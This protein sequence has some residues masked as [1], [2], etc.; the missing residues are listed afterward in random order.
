MKKIVLPFLFLIITSCIYSQQASDLFKKSD[1]KITYLGIDFSKVRLIGS[2]NQFA[3]AGST[4]PLLIKNKYFDAWNNIVLNESKKYDV[5][6]IF[7]KETIKMDIVEMS[8]INSKTELEAIEAEITPKYSVDFIK[9]HVSNYKFNEKEGFGILFIAE[10]LDKNAQEGI[11]HF[12]ILNLKNNEI[13]IHER[14][15]EHA[16]GIGLRNYWA[17]TIFEA[18][19][20]LQEVKYKSWKKKYGK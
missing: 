5:A 17:R 15:I 6:W 7:R 18:I 3:E 19:L 9:N 8:G 4:G 14:L 1:V 16:G 11:Y 2:F 20:E 12:V 13:I 10:S